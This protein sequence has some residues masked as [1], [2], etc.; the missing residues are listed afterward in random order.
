MSPSAAATPSMVSA[1]PRIAVAVVGLGR[2]PEADEVGEDHPPPRRQRVE[3]R[4]EVVRVGREPVQHEQRREA[5]V[6]VGGRLVAHV[7]LVAADG[8]GRRRPPARPRRS[9][10]PPA[11]SSGGR[12]LRRHA[13]RRGCRGSPASAAG[14]ARPGGRSGAG[15]VVGGLLR[16]AGASAVSASASGW[17]RPRR[18][19]RR[20][21]RWA[22]RRS[23][24]RARARRRPARRRVWPP[25]RVTVTTEPLMCTLSHAAGGEEPPGQLVDRPLEQLAGRLDVA[26]V[27]HA[28]QRPVGLE[29]QDGRVGRWT[30]SRRR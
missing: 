16:R 14:V 30:A 26:L 5:G 23:G 7:D 29:P 25:P 6:G 4:R 19:A 1:A 28:R 12:R 18:A 17:R 21:C 11:G 22:S 2:Q 3:H 13:R 8:R 9:R 20:R 10:Q 27:A 24:G 15:R